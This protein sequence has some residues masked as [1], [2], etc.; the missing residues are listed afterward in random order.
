MKK[1]TDASDPNRFNSQQN[2][3]DNQNIQYEK[4]N[5]KAFTRSYRMNL[6]RTTEFISSTNWYEVP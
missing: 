3:D 6:P 4:R 5:G 2:T 1:D